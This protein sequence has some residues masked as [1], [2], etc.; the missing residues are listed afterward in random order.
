MAAIY[1]CRGLWAYQ[2]SLAA[3]LNHPDVAS[4][5]ICAFVPM[6]EMVPHS[7]IRVHVHIIAVQALLY[8]Y[9]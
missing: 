9:C 8:Y 2:S 3:C 5:A 6:T 1:H 7:T 4:Y